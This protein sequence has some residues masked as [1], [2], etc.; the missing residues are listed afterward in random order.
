MNKSEYT[1]KPFCDTCET[2]KNEL[3]LMEAL[4]DY[5]NVCNDEKKSRGS[6]VWLGT[7]ILFFIIG[8]L[9]FRQRFEQPQTSLPETARETLNISPYLTLN[10]PKQR[11]RLA[12]LKN[13]AIRDAFDTSEENFIE[14]QTGQEFSYRS[15]ALFNDRSKTIAFKHRAFSL[16]TDTSSIYKWLHAQRIQNVTYKNFESYLSFNDKIFHLNDIVSQKYHV[17]W[18]DIDPVDRKIFF[19]D[20]NNNYYAISF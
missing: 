5:E 20:E 6:S 13:D 12:D 19:S 4:E 10:I 1:E 17:R 2:E 11:F 16:P 9:A 7:V 18:S 15:N 14:S 8:C 3:P